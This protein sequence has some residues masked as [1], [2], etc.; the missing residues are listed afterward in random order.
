MPAEEFN[1]TAAVNFD[2]ERGRVE[3]DSAA[4]RILVPADALL[5]L[6][7]E[8]GDDALR[9]FGRRLG[10]EAGRRVSER[11]SD[12]LSTATVESIVEHLG[13]DLALMGLG[14]LGAERWGSALVFTFADC[15]L[16]T[17]GHGVLG[18]VIE[19]A[20]QRTFS[21]DVAAVAL[22]QED[23]QLRL[24]VVAPSAAQKVRDWLENGVAW[25]EVLTRLHAT[26][27]RG[28]Q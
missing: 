12:G 3:L 14:S 17:A 4:A 6:C 5:D 24:I 8:A 11:L 18:A 15:P 25:G 28:P 10:S 20:L 26:T 27:E 22:H 23:E 21:R 7:R 13:G 19:G 9:D 16:G 1:P 2:L